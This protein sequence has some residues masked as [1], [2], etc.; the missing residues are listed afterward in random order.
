[1]WKMSN[2]VSKNGK[3]ED[4]HGSFFTNGV[5]EFSYGSR[6]AAIFRVP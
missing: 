6:G 5:I 2:E 1:M 4:F 3:K